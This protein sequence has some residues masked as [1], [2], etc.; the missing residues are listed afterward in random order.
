MPLYNGFER[1]HTAIHAFIGPEST[2]I[3]QEFCSEF[4]FIHTPSRAGKPGLV[5]TI[6]TGSFFCICRMAFSSARNHR[7]KKAQVDFCDKGCCATE[8]AVRSAST[9]L[10]VDASCICR[11]YRNWVSRNGIHTSSGRRDKGI[12]PGFDPAGPSYHRMRWRGCVAYFFISSSQNQTY[13]V[14]M[15]S[16]YKKMPGYK[17]YPFIIKNRTC[18]WYLP[19]SSPL[20]HPFLIPHLEHKQVPEQAVVI[21]VACKSAAWYGLRLPAWKA[22]AW[23]IRFHSCIHLHNNEGRA[24]ASGTP[25][26]QSPSWVFPSF[27]SVHIC[28]RFGGGY[29][30]CFRSLVYRIPAGGQPIQWCG[31]RAGVRVL[32]GTLMPARS[33]LT[34][35]SSTIYVL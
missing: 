24:A 7:P 21:S 10:P 9:A 25:V 5:W 33:T 19:W 16:V 6:S 34:R 29:V 1:F 11:V 14:N 23:Q 3:V 13:C 2:D 12:L 22:H 27:P 15:I 8:W 32:P 28:E 30:C 18:L 4:L 17:P 26:R 20:I 31:G 35:I